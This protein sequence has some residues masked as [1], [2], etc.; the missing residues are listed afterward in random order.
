[1]RD[2][3]SEVPV[4]LL[5]TINPKTMSEKSEGPEQL[6]PTGAKTNPKIPIDLQ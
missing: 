5:K 4:T 6:Q 1:M 3:I 2:L